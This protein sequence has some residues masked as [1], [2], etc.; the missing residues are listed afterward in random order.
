M[1]IRGTARVTCPACGKAQDC[2]LVQSINTRTNPA[3]KQ[4]L[5]AGELDVLACECGK[6]TQLAAR[7]V[8]HDPDADYYCQVVPGGETG[9][10]PVL[11]ISVGD[12]NAAFALSGRLQS[13]DTPVH[14][15]ERRAAQ[16]VL[17]VDPQVLQP[18]D[19]AALA[20]AIRNAFV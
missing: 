5:L 3:D 11:E 18:E 1:V 9:R 7:L 6:R 17:I 4:R 19:D 20:A 14:L 10:V 15:S 12:A 13:L 16:G 8:F 2:E